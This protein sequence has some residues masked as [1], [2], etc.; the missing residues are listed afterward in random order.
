LI[1][2]WLQA[3]IS[4]EAFFNDYNS[5]YARRLVAW[6][7]WK[8]VYARL[9]D[10]AGT[11]VSGITYTNIAKC[12]QYPGKETSRQRACSKAFPLRDLVEVLRPTGV[13]LLAPD[14]WVVQ[15][16]GTGV[17]DVPL[18]NDSAPHFQ[19]PAHRMAAAELWVKGLSAT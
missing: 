9:A 5:E 18:M 8:K 19:L 12:W 16:P 4:D 11:D 14:A 7:P 13:F 2:A 15:V 10:T 3:E 6:G 17:G 1:R